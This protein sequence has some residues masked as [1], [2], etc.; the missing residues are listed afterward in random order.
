MFLYCFYFISAV[1]TNFIDEHTNKIN[2]RDE[3]LFTLS[4]DA[5][6]LTEL[7]RKK[8]YSIP[9]NRRLQSELNRGRAYNL[10]TSASQKASQAF[11]LF[12][13]FNFPFLIFFLTTSFMFFRLKKNSA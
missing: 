7:S 10:K 5:T 11:S 12:F 6:V 1:Y 2:D 13:I 3:S 4:S 8:G 9:S